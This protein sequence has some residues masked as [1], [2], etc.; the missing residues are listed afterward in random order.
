MVAQRFI[1]QFRND[2]NQGSHQTDRKQNNPK[3]GIAVSV[4]IALQLSFMMRGVILQ[5][6]L[7]QLGKQSL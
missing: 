3:E 2:G 6:L 7:L 5:P 1:V 4:I